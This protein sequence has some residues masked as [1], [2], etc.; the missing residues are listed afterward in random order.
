MY[1]PIAMA[2][3]WLVLAIMAFI[4]SSRRNPQ[5]GIDLTIRV[6][7]PNGSKGSVRE[8]RLANLISQGKVVAYQPFEDWVELRRK[9]TDVYMGVERRVNVLH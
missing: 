7:Y 2:I 6:I 3:T 4:M 8:S 1:V 9:I 5:G